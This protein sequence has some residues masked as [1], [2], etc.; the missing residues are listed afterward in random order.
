VTARGKAAGFMTHLIK[1]VRIESLESA[2][3]LVKKPADFN[4]LDRS[5]VVICQ[6]P[7]P[8]RV[9]PAR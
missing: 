5:T 1:P 8:T 6:S 7:D 2:L 9:G 4:F 3:A